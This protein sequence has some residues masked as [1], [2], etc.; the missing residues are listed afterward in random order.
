MKKYIDIIYLI[1]ITK[2][3]EMFKFLIL[4]SKKF[5]LIIILIL[6]FFSTKSKFR[7]NSFINKLN[8]YSIFR[9]PKYILLFDYIYSPVCEDLNSYSIFQYYQNNNNSDAYYIL[10]EQTELYKSLYKQNKTTNIIPFKNS[11]DI[12][13][14]FDYFLHSKIIIQSYTLYTFQIIASQVKYLKFL[15]VCHAVNYFKTIIIKEQLLK[16]KDEKKNLI[17]TS[18]YEYNLYKKLNLYKEKSMH[19]AGLARYD[20][21]K[22]LKSNHS[23]K[24]CILLSFT[25]RSYNNSIYEKSLYKRN[26]NKLLTDKSLQLSLEQNDID[27]IFIQHHYDVLMKRQINKIIFPHLKFFEQ[28][29]LAYYIEK[30]SLL[31]TDFSSISFDFMFQN[32]PVLF[33]YLDINDTT[34]FSEKEYMRIDYSNNIYYNNIFLDQKSLV[35]SI[36]SYI[37]RKFVLE[38][39]LARKYTTL[40]YYKNNITQKIVKIINN[41]IDNI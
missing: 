24:K 13:K 39:G 41:I 18:P 40:F 33:Y 26:I 32:K 38:K 16:L 28:K 2:N 22:Y 36:I 6:L 4:R 15:Y 5:I 1:K 34:N 11:N 10:N 20:R 21:F 8:K 37:N 29:Y 12:R 27:L 7:L 30:C 14:M 35:N 17:V 3:G 23:E 19:I 25:Y 31:I 9:Q